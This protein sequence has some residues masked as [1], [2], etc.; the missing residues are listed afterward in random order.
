M[1]KENIGSLPSCISDSFLKVFTRRIGQQADESTDKFVFAVNIQVPGSR[2]FSI[3]YYYVLQ[4]PVDEVAYTASVQT[5]NYGIAKSCN[6]AQKSLFGRFIHGTNQF[7]NS[8]LKLI[9]NVALGPWVVQ[10]AVGT[11]PLIVGRALKVRVNP[12]SLSDKKGRILCSTGDIPLF[13]EIYGDR[14]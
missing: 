12:F 8:R 5:N 13:S 11:K 1:P 4:Y 3:V 2:H 7:R 10:R 6:F 9:P 14:H